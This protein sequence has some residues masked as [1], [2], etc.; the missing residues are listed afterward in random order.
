MRSTREIIADP[1]NKEA[2]QN[3]G[4]LLLPFIIA[5]ATLRLWNST[6]IRSFSCVGATFRLK[7]CPEE[8]WTLDFLMRV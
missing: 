8:R 1:A 6:T 5:P 7:E 2:H 3:S 4:L